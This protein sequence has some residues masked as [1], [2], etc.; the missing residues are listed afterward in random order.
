MQNAQVPNKMRY[1]FLSSLKKRLFYQRKYETQEKLKMD[2]FWYI[3]VYYNRFRKHSANDY[4]T[5]DKKLS[6]YI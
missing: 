6:P 5:P 3:E 2:L 1:A 4:L